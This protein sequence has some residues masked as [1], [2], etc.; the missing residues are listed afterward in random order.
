MSFLTG[1]NFLLLPNIRS[2]RLESSLLVLNK[3]IKLNGC[4]GVFRLRRAKNSPALFS[5]SHSRPGKAGSRKVPT[6]GSEEGR[7]MAADPWGIRSEEVVGSRGK[8]ISCLQSA[9]TTAKMAWLLLSSF[10]ESSRR[11]G[12]RREHEGINPKLDWQIQ[13]LEW[14]ARP[15]FNL[16]ST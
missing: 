7:G 5:E 15:K 13:S 1:L 3:A 11:E 9:V 10:E 2:T 6:R 14:I 16:F 12:M 4:W 8:E